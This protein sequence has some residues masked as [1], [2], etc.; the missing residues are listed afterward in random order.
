MQEEGEEQ[1]GRPQGAVSTALTE[2]GQDGTGT[3][4]DAQ[5]P[6]AV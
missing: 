4:T 5:C 2:A 6:C 1:V 3:W